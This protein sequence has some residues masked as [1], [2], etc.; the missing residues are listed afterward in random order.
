MCL[1]NDHYAL[2]LYKA[3]GAVLSLVDLDTGGELTLGS[4]GGCLWGAVFTGDQYVGGCSYHRNGPNTFDYAW[5]PIQTTLTFTYTWEAGIYPRVDAVFTLTA[6]DETFFDVQ[7][8]LENQWGTMMRDVLLPSDLLFEDD[9]IQAAYGPFLMPGV[10]LG[11]GF[12]TADRTYIPV[13]PSDAAFAD[14]LALD[15][16][17]GRLAVYTINPSPNSIQPVT[18][19]FIDDEGYNPGT[20]YTYHR[21]HTWVPNGQTW[22]SPPV[23]LHIGQS[24][25]ETMLTYRQENGIDGYPSLADKLGTDLLTLVQSPLIK[26]HVSQPFQDFIPDLD[27]LPSPLLLH[28]VAYQPR[29]HDENYPDFLPPDP[30]WGTTEDFQALVEAAQA[31]GLLVAPYINPT[32]WDDESPTVQ[33][34]SPL[35]IT[36]IAVLDEAGQPVSEVYNG[37][38]GYAISPQVDFVVQRLD[39]LMAQWQDEVPVDCILEDQIGARSWRRDFNASASSPQLYSDG[40]LTHTRTYADR[41]LMTEMGWDRLAE[42]E[43]G[44]HGSLLTWEREFEYGD[45]YWGSGNWE[46]Y[47]LALWLFHDKVLLYQ[48]DLSLLTMSADK[49]VLTWNLAF[50]TMLSY[51]WQW[52]ENDLPDVPWLDLVVALQRAVV[53]RTAGQMLTDY[54]DL[55][56]SVTQSTFGEISVIA[57][58]DPA[59]TYLVDGHYISPGGFLARTS[60]NTVLAGVFDGFF[61]GAAITPG[62]HY[63]ILERMASA[64]IV[65]HPVGSETPLSIDA[66]DDWQEGETLQVQAFDRTGNLLDDVDFEMEGRMVLFTCHQFYGDQYVAYYRI[67][68]QRRVYLPLLVRGS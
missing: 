51:D 28:P 38:F 18:L 13:Y 37:H 26:I 60:D 25:Q 49:E 32:W 48:H 68:G 20:F 64:V 2:T 4:R 19:G 27:L 15:T 33:N 56:T 12:F 8:A 35:T 34:L 36:D 54:A 58:W 57:N 14:Y 67:S 29:G 30:Q 43:V 31:E 3:N 41:C 1:S 50:G 9:A 46:P 55:Q 5:D 10:R 59:Q 7:L 40:W 16:S 17:G 24:P 66:P 21:L 65:R 39:Q 44:F 6:S 61:N 53:A 62:D 45:Q 23:R 63:V 52:I 22:T 11:P 42:T 47:P